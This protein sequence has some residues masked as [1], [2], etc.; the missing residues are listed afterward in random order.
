MLLSKAYAGS[1][2]AKSTCPKSGNF[3]EANPVDYQAKF[4]QLWGVK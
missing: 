2:P 4:K 3:S 1:V